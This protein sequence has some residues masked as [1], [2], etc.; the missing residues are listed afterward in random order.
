MNASKSVSL[1]ECMEAAIFKCIHFYLRIITQLSERLK[2]SSKEEPLIET[3]CEECD[4]NIRAKRIEIVKR[5]MID[6]MPMLVKSD[7]EY[8]DD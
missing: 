5:E 4:H 7:L 2:K 3:R 1:E 6:H 8:S